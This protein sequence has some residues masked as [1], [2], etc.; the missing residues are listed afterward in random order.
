M[1]APLDL[2]AERK[3]GTEFPVEVGLSPVQTKEGILVMSYLTDITERR[4]AEEA[5]RAALRR[6]EEVDRLKTQLLS[7]VSHE[8]RTPLTS[9]RGQTT[10]LLDYAD[11][12]TPEER[13]EALADCG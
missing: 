7:I 11:Q 10:T 3:D 2:W 6:A 1:N 13:L 8:L 5:L 4:R 12:V 9:I